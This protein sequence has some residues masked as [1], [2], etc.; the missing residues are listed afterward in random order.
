MKIIIMKSW[1]LPERLLGRSPEQWHAA[2]RGDCWWE[3]RSPKQIDLAKSLDEFFIFTM[4]A[5]KSSCCRSFIA[6]VGIV[7]AMLKLEFM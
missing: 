7:H 6:S 4:S 3:S 1:N 2:C 5:E